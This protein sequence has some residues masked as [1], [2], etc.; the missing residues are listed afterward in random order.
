M[1][2]LMKNNDSFTP[3]MS[4]DNFFRNFFISPMVKNNGMLKTDIKEDENQYT[5]KV[6]APGF[7]KKD[8]HVTYNDGVLT[9]AGKRDTVNDHADKDGNV[10]ASERSFGQVS[11]SYGLP[12]VDKMKISAKYH[13]GVLTLVLP[14]VA[15]AQ[16]D[17]NEINID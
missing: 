14:K 9:I 12:N 6:D 11:R 16:R 4:M 2:N 10:L 7:N 17:E 15:E 5:V 3:E 8:L 1:F 13:D